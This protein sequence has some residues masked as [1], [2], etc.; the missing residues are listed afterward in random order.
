MISASATGVAHPGRFLVPAAEAL[1]S[2]A[3]TLRCLIGVRRRALAAEGP[4]LPTTEKM[5]SARALVPRR[6]VAIVFIGA[7]RISARRKPA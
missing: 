5:E 7:T 2:S 6:R 3:K 4:G 1:V